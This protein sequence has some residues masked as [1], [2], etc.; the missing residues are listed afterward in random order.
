M[1]FLIT[2]KDE[3]DSPIYEVW[4][5]NNKKIIFYENPVFSKKLVE[6]VKSENSQMEN[7][8]IA[9]SDCWDFV[10]LYMWLIT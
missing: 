9:K 1:Q 7:G 5:N 3:Y 6:Y 10:K 2:K 8:L 4:G